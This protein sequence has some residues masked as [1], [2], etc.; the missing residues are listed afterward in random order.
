DEEGDPLVALAD[1]YHFASALARRAGPDE[2]AIYTA[3]EA[4]AAGAQLVLAWIRSG[5]G[6]SSWSVPAQRRAVEELGMRYAVL[7]RPEAGARGTRRGGA[8]RGG[9]GP[10]RPGP[11]PPP[12]APRGGGSAGLH[13]RVRAGEPLA[14][15][16]ADTPHELLR[17]L[18]V[19]YVVNQWWA[20]ICAAKQ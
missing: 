20:S 19:P 13:A 12:P 10:G 1:R 18:D 2:R 11:P 5:D 7:D 17:T 16:D 15:V 14:V 8:G 4:E 9:G 6:A 3:E